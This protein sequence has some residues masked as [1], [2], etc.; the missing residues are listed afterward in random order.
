MNLRRPLLSVSVAFLIAASLAL[1]S[2]AS[3]AAAPSAPATP[4][5]TESGKSFAPGPL[6]YR[7][8]I[9]G[10]IEST[11]C[12]D[13]SSLVC[14]GHSPNGCS[15]SARTANPQWISCDGILHVCP[16]VGQ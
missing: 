13:G 9:N 6:E 10:C 5:P 1:A 4:P 12:P 11:E 3:A 8:P 16:A 7:I 2:L 15:R 14:V